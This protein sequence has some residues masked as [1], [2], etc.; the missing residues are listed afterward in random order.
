MQGSGQDLERT[1]KVHEVEA[2]LQGKEHINWLVCHRG[3][4]AGHLWQQ[5]VGCLMGSGLMVMILDVARM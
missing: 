1:G 4:L 2:G 3:A 5:W